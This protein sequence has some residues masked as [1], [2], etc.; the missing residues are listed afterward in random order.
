MSDGVCSTLLPGWKGALSDLDSSSRERATALAAWRLLY[1]YG[2][3]VVAGGELGRRPPGLF[4]FAGKSGYVAGAPP[5]HPAV[6]A[7]MTELE[8]TMGLPGW[9]ELAIVMRFVGDYGGY[10]A[11]SRQVPATMM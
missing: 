3:C 11:T 1:Y 6:R 10:I 9:D 4:V 2:G 8:T 7:I 5:E